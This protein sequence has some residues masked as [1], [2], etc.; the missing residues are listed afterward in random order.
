MAGSAGLG[1]KQRWYIAPQTWEDL[2]SK[3]SDLRAINAELEKKGALEFD[4]RTD[5]EK[6]QKRLKR[7]MINGLRY[8]FYVVTPKILQVALDPSEEGSILNSL[9]P[10]LLSKWWAGAQF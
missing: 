2:V 4:T 7:I 6:P 9:W 8:P 5:R 3:V 1:E 10:S